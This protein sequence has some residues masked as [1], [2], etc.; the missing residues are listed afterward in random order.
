LQTFLSHKYGYRPFPPKITAAEFEAI[1]DVVQEESD[2]ELLRKWFLKDE[3]I[4]PTTYVLQPITELLPNYG[5]Q[6]LSKDERSKA[7]GEWWTAFERMQVVFRQAADQLFKDTPNIRW[8]YY[9]SGT[10]TDLI[11]SSYFRHLGPMNN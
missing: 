7:S 3:N 5:D 2:K 10:F 1:F 4:L 6:S 9:Q 11:T 8:K